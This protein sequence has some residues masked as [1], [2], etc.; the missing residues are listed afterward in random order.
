MA[1]SA[2]AAIFWFMLHPWR[3]LRER[4][5]LTL[6]VRDLGDDGPLGLTGGSTIVL[7]TGL[8]Q[9]ER[10]CVLLHELIHLERGIPHSADDREEAAIEHEVARRLVPFAELV[11]ALRW[12]CEVDEVAEA[13]WVMPHLIRVCMQGLHPAELSVVQEVLRHHH[14]P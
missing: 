5:D 2:A 9:V 12:S 11:E 10:R 1:L 14:V 8:L 4:D 13:C 6:S 3:L 7:T